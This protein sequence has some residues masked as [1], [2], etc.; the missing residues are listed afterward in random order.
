M[1]TTCHPGVFIPVSIDAKSIK[2][3]QKVRELWSKIKCHF[4]IGRRYTFCC[5]IR[6]R[7][8]RVCNKAYIEHEYVLLSAVFFQKSLILAKNMIDVRRSCTEGISTRQVT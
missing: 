1:Q 5:F 2:I 6:A 4:F 7:L 8:M 3:S